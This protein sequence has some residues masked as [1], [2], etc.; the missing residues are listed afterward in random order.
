[1]ITIRKGF[2]N[3]AF[4]LMLVIFVF[5]LAF[6]QADNQSKV[7]NQS[8]KSEDTSQKP[9]LQKNGEG[10]SESKASRPG[11][12]DGSGKPKQDN[13][14]VESER[15]LL[16]TSAI[17]H[18][19]YA[20]NDL[21]D[22]DNLF[23]S[24]PIAQLIIKRLSPYNKDMCRDLLESLFVKLMKQVE[25]DK[26]KGKLV[27]E[28]SSSTYFYKKHL[29]SI[30]SAAANVDPELAESFVSRFAEKESFLTT[31]DKTAMNL[32]LAKMLIAD[33]PTQSIEIARKSIGEAVTY[34]SLEY[35]GRLRQ[36][37]PILAKNYL[38]SLMHNIETRKMVS[39]NEL[40]Y[41]H[42]YV[43]LSRT[44]P[45]FESGQLGV[46]HNV[47]Y[48]DGLEK[49]AV[50]VILIQ[51][52]VR[53][54]AK[55]ILREERFSLYELKI[56]DAQSDLVFINVA[57][58][59]SLKYLPG[60]FVSQ[61]LPSLF[62]RK[63]LLAT[64]LAPGSSH[65]VQASV[66]R[67][68][69]FKEETTKNTQAQEDDYESVLKE[70]GKK[71]SQSKK[72]Q[73]YFDTSR[74]LIG[75]KKYTE[76]LDI[77]DKMSDETIK[78]Q[79]RGFVL[80]E[81]AQ[82]VLNENKPEEAMRWIFEDNNLIRRSYLLTQIASYY[83][84]KGNQPEKMQRVEDILIEISNSAT[85]MP[86]GIEKVAAFSGMTVVLSKFDKMRAIDY[87]RICVQAAND[88]EKFK[89]DTT[90]NMPLPINGFY[91]SQSL[92]KG[93]FGFSSAFEQLGAEYFNQV[94]GEAKVLNNKIAR[95]IAV[96]SVCNM[97]LS[98]K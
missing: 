47:D 78:S 49:I 41:L 32:S 96:T 87:L 27:N 90:I 31:T 51:E 9:S 52:Y 75:K 76:S 13:L 74:R 59:P 2:I 61:M 67:F 65:E 43:T 55:I 29:Q 91:Y 92:Y 50:D 69:S 15:E 33:S 3:S 26:A 68:N 72:D 71:Y 19:E 77:L 30:I 16:K 14:G 10:R 6:A 7:K 83:L 64:M 98:Q 35:L 79:A 25:S 54:A 53:V 89:G 39:I 81:I 80:F 57:L 34:H 58:L 11:S 70:N 93:S 8:N 42:S 22:V 45:I 24:I 48:G 46:L 95:V 4:L 5:Q 82:A 12:H 18:L 38:I 86:S 62:V 1:M 84:S 17:K 63:E 73:I 37:D 36:K 56:A 88:A 21:K 94:V 40:F 85:A 44:I 20:I 28:D 23:D 60:E 66:D 97:I